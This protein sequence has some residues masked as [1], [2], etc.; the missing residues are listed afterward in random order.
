MGLSV[1]QRDGLR[2]WEQHNFICDLP[3]QSQE[4]HASRQAAADRF[5]LMRKSLPPANG[6]LNMNAIAERDVSVRRA[7]NAASHPAEN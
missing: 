3:G 2:L 6:V 5:A 4:S 1:V 7:V